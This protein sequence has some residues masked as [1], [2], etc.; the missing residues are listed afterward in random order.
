MVGY[1]FVPNFW[2]IL[3]ALS[4]IFNI[5][6]ICSHNQKAFSCGCTVTILNDFVYFFDDE[7][8]FCIDSKEIRSVI[9]FP[10]NN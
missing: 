5:Q 2:R 3:V 4:S 9:L 1:C 8:Y 10:I 7:S 6:Q